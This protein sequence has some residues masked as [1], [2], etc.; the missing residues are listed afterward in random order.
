MPP[1]RSR[2]AAPGRLGF[3]GDSS[4]NGKPLLGGASGRCPECGLW[5][6]CYAVKK[7][8]DK[9]CSTMRT[10]RPTTGSPFSFSEAGTPPFDTSEVSA[11]FR[12]A[13]R[14]WTRPPEIA[15][16]LRASLISLSPGYPR[17]GLLRLMPTVAREP[18]LIVRRPERT[19]LSVRR[20][21]RVCCGV[22]A[23]WKSITVS[24][25]RR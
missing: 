23:A 12:F 5:R 17:K 3:L 24:R 11:S 4:V 1:P 9:V 8:L 15:F 14:S 22:W 7:R 19:G 2:S 18:C 21:F 10:A 16:A 25:Q 13:G 6:A 20:R